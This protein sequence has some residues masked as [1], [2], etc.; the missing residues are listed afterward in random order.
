MKR[1][2]PVKLLLVYLFFMAWF[3]VIVVRMFTL[4]LTKGEAYRGDFTDTLTVDDRFFRLDST[5]LYGF[6]GNVY[7]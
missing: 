6:R 5:R 4:V 2:L 3:V 1:R 7:A